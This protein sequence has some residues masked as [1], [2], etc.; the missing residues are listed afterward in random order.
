MT[1][2]A[3]LAYKHMTDACELTHT[4]IILYASNKKHKDRTYRQAKVRNKIMPN[5]PR[6][7]NVSEKKLSWDF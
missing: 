3:Y 1:E 5:F 2:L 7:A 6:A 4:Y